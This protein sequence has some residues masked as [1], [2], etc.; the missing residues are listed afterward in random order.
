MLQALR[1]V[2]YPFTKHSIRIRTED[3][4]VQWELCKRGHGLCVMMQ[5]VGD[6]ERRVRRA[7][8]DGAPVITLPV[9]LVSHR[10]LRTNQR[11][12]VVYDAIADAFSG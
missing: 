9:W 10:E 6:Q 11:I 2:G 1:V 7:L 8:P 3:H 4:L 12:R 5:E